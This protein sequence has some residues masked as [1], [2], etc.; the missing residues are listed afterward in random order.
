MSLASFKFEGDIKIFQKFMNPARTSKIIEQEIKKA[1]L[2]NALFLIKAIQKNMR[3]KTFKKNSPLTLAL[4]QSKNPLI[5]ERNLFDAIRHKLKNSFEAEVGIIRNQNSTGG[6]G[7]KTIPMQKLVELMERGYTIKVTPKM[8]Q[9]IAIKLKG[10]NIPQAEDSNSDGNTTYFVPPRPLF[11]T[12]FKDSRVS[13]EIQKRYS[14]GLEKA[15]LRMGAQ[16]G[17]HR[18]K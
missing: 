16:G 9:A 10:L 13:L 18:N 2:T 7:G 12:V 6:F 3:N 14:L 1:T 5:N 17:D 4:K 8:K 15:F 11:S